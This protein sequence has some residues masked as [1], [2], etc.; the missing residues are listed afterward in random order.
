MTFSFNFQVDDS[1]SN[2]INGGDEKKD[3][4]DEAIEWKEAK[5]HFISEVHKEI[6]SHLQNIET[7]HLDDETSVHVISSESVTNKLNHS[8]YSGDLAP[9]LQGDTDL[10]PGHYEVSLNISV[11]ES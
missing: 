10:L 5:E 11:I 3:S 7:I 2:N 1:D 6:V 4:K 8:E 9:A